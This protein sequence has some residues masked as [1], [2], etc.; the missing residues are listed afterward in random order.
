[1]LRLLQHLLRVVYMLGSRQLDQGKAFSAWTFYTKGF[2]RL[3]PTYFLTNLAAAIMIFAL[4]EDDED[5]GWM[6]W[7]VPMTTLG[8]TSWSP[9]PYLPLNEVTWL[10][11]TLMAFYVLF[12][13]LAPRVQRSVLPGQERVAAICLYLLSA[14]WPAVLVFLGT[15]LSFIAGCTW[16]GEGSIYTETC[17]GGEGSIWIARMW[18]PCRLPVFVMGM[19]AAKMQVVSEEDVAVVM[20]GTPVLKTGASAFMC[21]TPVFKVLGVTMADTLFLIYLAMIGTAFVPAL[22]IS[23]IPELLVSM[24]FFDWV[25]ALCR[26]ESVTRR[27]LSSHPMTFLGD[28]S[29]CFYMVHVLVWWGLQALGLSGQAWGL[30][31]GIVF[32]LLVGWL[33]HCFW[34]KPMRNFILSRLLGD[35]QASSDPCGRDGTMWECIPLRHDADC[36]AASPQTVSDSTDLVQVSIVG[37]SAVGGNG[38]GESV[39]GSA[40]DAPSTVNTI[41]PCDGKAPKPRPE[42]ER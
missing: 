13:F 32:S 8:I 16:R 19:L 38:A 25:V 20:G 3:A 12:P 35:K 10:V 14:S 9:V 7:I 26:E 17:W 21:D 5:L 6:A 30:P 22:T 37:A 23:F 31:V 24:L 29:M 1:M 4:S 39:H 42:P 40:N 36:G 33:L 2:A 11:S 27:F 15:F 18:P 28:I 34:E 41:Y